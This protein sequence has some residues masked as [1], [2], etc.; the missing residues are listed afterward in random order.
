[1]RVSELKERE[2]FDRIFLESLPRLL[3]LY[4][5][6][7]VQ[8]LR[9][10]NSGDQTWLLQPFLTACYVPHA[11]S[12]V[13]RFLNESIAYTSSGLRAPFQWIFA[14]GLSTKLGLGLTGQPCFSLSNPIPAARELLIVPGNNRVRL[15]DF[16]RQRCLVMQK[17]G[18][19]TAGMRREIEARTSVPGFCLSVLRHGGDYSWLEEPIF[20]GYALARCPPWLPRHNLESN[21]LRT[22]YHHTL[23]RG[24]HISSDEWFENL[25]HRLNAGLAKLPHQWGSS[26]HRL[27]SAI[28]RLGRA[29]MGMSHV[30]VGETHGDMQ[31]GNVLVS[32]SGEDLRII[33]WESAAERLS[34]YD[35]LT[36]QLGAR[37]GRRI[38]KEVRRLVNGGESSEE[39][40]RLPRGARE[41]RAVVATFLLED[42]LWLVE[43]ELSGPFHGP[44][45]AWRHRLA[46]MG[47]L[48]ALV[49]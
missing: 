43:S 9:P 23:E 13:R 7:G 33:D 24:R 12:R 27:R 19:S 5:S 26:G 37:R 3:E 47:E 44:S 16:V 8:V 35:V 42:L 31:P 29:M 48:A 4:G 49:D 14:C 20:D 32:R 46:C 34:Y 10:V 30:Y 39:C 2:D 38:V 11:S 17:T 6:V 45:L 28:G 22:L 21:A 18:F 15:Y 1:M 25:S 40:F 41:R 36:Y